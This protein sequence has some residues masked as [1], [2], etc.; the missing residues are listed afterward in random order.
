MICIVYHLWLILSHFWGRGSLTTSL[1]ETARH[2][3]PESIETVSACWSYLTILALY[4]EAW[5]SL[6]VVFVL[7][8]GGRRRN[9]GCSTVRENHTR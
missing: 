7:H 8:V 4:I 1:G 9:G 5:R 6:E 3:F 2:V